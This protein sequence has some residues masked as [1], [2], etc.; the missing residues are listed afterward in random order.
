M[1][2][3]IGIQIIIY[4]FISPLIVSAIGLN[5]AFRMDISIV[6]VLSVIVGVF[7]FSVRIYKHPTHAANEVLVSFN[8]PVKLLIALGG[9]LYIIVV[10]KNDLLYRRIGSHEAARLYSEMTITDKSVLR[11][12]EILFFPILILLLKSLKYD[13]S[14]FTRILLIIQAIGFLFTGVADSR[15]KILM[16]GIFIYIY[17]VKTRDSLFTKYK[18]IWV[19]IGICFLLSSVGVGLSRVESFDNGNELVINDILVRVNGLELISLVDKEIGIPALGT[20]DFA[21]F[22]NFI[23]AIP[24]LELSRDLK[25]AGSTSSKNYYLNQILSTKLLDCNNSFLTDLFYFAGY[26]GLILGG[27]GWG[28]I[29]KKVDFYL[30]TGRVW[31]NRITIAWVFSISINALKIEVDFFGAIISSLRDFLLIL[32]FLF[33]VEFRKDQQE[34]C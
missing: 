29:A 28:F 17:F 8:N 25:E 32:V 3:I 13:K 2:N 11:V 12:F 33:M 26:L 4:L 7:W 19:S 34:R 16:P 27:V 1:Q 30:L 10:V 5:Q 20:F 18:K 15:S 21:I 22:D 9:L 24:F 6:F 31:L 14:V 23:S